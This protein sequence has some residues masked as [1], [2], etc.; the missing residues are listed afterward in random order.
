MM[1]SA[2]AWYEY[3]SELDGEHNSFP[4]GLG[5]PNPGELQPTS[6]PTTRGKTSTPPKKKENRPPIHTTGTPI[7]HDRQYRRHGPTRN[8]PP[9]CLLQLRGEPTHSNDKSKKHPTGTNYPTTNG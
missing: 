8:T 9:H 4:P 3:E 5:K 2:E 1:E 7:T 6:P